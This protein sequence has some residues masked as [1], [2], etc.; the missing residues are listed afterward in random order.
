M[1]ASRSA[2][3]RKGPPP[4]GGAKPGGAA[5]V[6]KARTGRDVS[7]PL[8]PIAVVGGCAAIAV[9]LVATALGQ[10][11][12]TTGNVSTTAAIAWIIGSVVGLLAFSWF[13]S[14]DMGCRAEPRYVEPS[15][16]PRLLAI[17]IAVVGWV[18][19][20]IGAFLVAEALARR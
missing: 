8:L 9:V 7:T 1:T 20:S 16:R 14:V 13:R 17:W 19:G 3:Q 6:A 4:K 11:A 2:P 15:W 5:A 12:G 10:H 18:A